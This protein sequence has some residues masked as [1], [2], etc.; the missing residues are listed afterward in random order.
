MHPYYEGEPILLPEK[1][2]R[3]TKSEGTPSAEKPAKPEAPAEP[4][5][6][7]RLWPKP[8]RR[9]QR[10]VDAIGNISFGG[11]VYNFGRAFSGRVV[12]VFTLNTVVHIAL[13]DR[14]S[15]ASCKIE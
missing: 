9:A 1:N 12:E 6:A 4:Q 2:V 7:K 14:R 10:R 15:S 3:R 8:D 5:L 11:A 13:D